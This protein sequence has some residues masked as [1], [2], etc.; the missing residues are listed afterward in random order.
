MIRLG[1]LAMANLHTFAVTEPYRK[2]PETALP[3]AAD[4]LGSNRVQNPM[5]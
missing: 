4:F 3:N 1:S 5:P 2:P